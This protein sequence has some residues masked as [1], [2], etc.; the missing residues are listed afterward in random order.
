M[1]HSIEL[2]FDSDTEAAVR[3]IWDELA[4]R[5]ALP[6]WTLQRGPITGDDVVASVLLHP[7]VHHDVAERTRGG[8][9]SGAGLDQLLRPL[10]VDLLAD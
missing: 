7:V 8:D 9:A 3:R 6:G 4:T 5:F 2:I 1:V 10:G